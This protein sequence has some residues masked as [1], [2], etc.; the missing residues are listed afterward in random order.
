MSFGLD[1]KLATSRHFTR[2]IILVERIWAVAII[3]LCITAL[4][5]TAS[6]FGLFARLPVIASYALLAVFGIALVYFLRPFL[7]LKWPSLSDINARL[8]DDNDIQHEGISIHDQAISQ[9]ENTHA[10]ALWKEH[11]TRMRKKLDDIKLGAPRSDLPDRDP[12]AFRV[13][14]LL[15]FVTGF[16]YSWSGQSG[17]TSDAFLAGFRQVQSPDLLRIDAWVTPPTYTNQAPIFLS[18]DIQND[19]IIAIPQTSEITVRVSS[20]DETDTQ[21]T[22]ELNFSAPNNDVV[23]LPPTEANGITSY[24]IKPENDG[25]LSVAKSEAAPLRNWQFSIIPDTAPEIQFEQEP[26]Q[27]LNGAIELI[28][29]AKD[30]Y[31]IVIARA[32]IAPVYPTDDHALPLYQLP[33]FDLQLPRRKSEDNLATTSYDLTDHPLAGEDVLITLVAIDGAGQETRSEPIETVLPAKNF[34]SPLAQSIIEQ[35]QV[36]AFDAY[37][38]PRVLELNDA[39]TILP[40][41]TIPNIRDFL[42]VKTAREGLALAYTD[43]ALLRWVDDLWN[44]ALLLEDGDLSLAEKKLRDAQRALTE[45]LKEGASDEEI[46]R[47]MDELRSAMEEYM[48]ALAQ[49]NN[50]NPQQNNQQSNAQEIDQESLNDI[51]DQIENMAKSGNREQAQQMLQDL[52]DMMNNMQ[53]NRQQQQQSGEQSQIEQQMDQLGQILRDQQELM[54]Q[55][56]D[57]GQRSD[58]PQQRLENGNSDEQ[59]MT[60]QQRSDALEQLKQQQQD[61]QQQLEDLMEKLEEQGLENAEGLGEAGE[62]MEGAAGELGE[63]DTGEAG[64]Q[65]GRALQA[66]RD[67]AQQMLNQMQ[68]QMQAQ[69][70]GQGQQGQGQ[71]QQGQQPGQ[72]G[73]GRGQGNQRDPLGRMQSNGQE[74]GNADDPLAKFSDGTNTQRAREILETIRKRLGENFRLDFEKKYLERLLQPS[75]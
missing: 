69:G 60:Q 8:E 45:A 44:I 2:I 20:L 62:A 30:D 4:F 1:G 39:L 38:L 73:Q 37:D 51:L 64:E 34:I 68:Q 19:K 41:E 24:Q 29:S 12:Y 31:G 10:S 71:G 6:W 63:G 57:L 70:Q 9:T 35:R 74:G 23:V 72:Q 14:T 52:Q 18:S 3:P 21:N 42:L 40:E 7:A 13:L 59:Q 33:E 50:Q 49:E 27:A 58:T 46:A 65:Q 61:L 5:F 48:Q 55:T 26:K 66:L 32:E 15:L 75:E 22:L 28:Y 53:A 16:A 36:L 43:E 56:L 25:K 67:G 11:Q 54:D 47:L 17:S